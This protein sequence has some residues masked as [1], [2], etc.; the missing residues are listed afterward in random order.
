MACYRVLFWRHDAC[1]GCILCFDKP[2]S[3]HGVYV[4][5]GAVQTDDGAVGAGGFVVVEHQ[6]R[7]VIKAGSEGA[8]LLHCRQSDD[9]P[10][11]PSRTGGRV[12]GV[13]RGGILRAAQ[14]SYGHRGILLAGADR[15]A[16]EVWLDR[17]NFE[18]P[19]ANA[20]GFHHHTA[21][22]IIFILQGE[23]LV[24]NR[25]LTPE[26]PLAIDEDTRYG[27]GVGENGRPI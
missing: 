11:K 20:S 10:E 9:I 5:E 26:P 22:E 24:G 7:A 18:R 1:P 6:A 8:T 14:P 17:S 27:F 19:T 23:M 3:D 12:H 25:K 13:D 2:G 16:C 4:F 15:P 21:D